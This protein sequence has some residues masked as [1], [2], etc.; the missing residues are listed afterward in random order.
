MWKGISLRS[1]ATAARKCKRGFTQLYRSTSDEI[2]AKKYR[3]VKE[4]LIISLAP[5]GIPL[6]NFS[7]PPYVDS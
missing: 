6:P 2:L 1:Q 5:F 3:Q 4:I 7:V